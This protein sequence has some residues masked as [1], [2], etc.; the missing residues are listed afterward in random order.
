VGDRDV[1]YVTT[2]HGTYASKAIWPEPD[3]PLAK[4]LQARLGARLKVIP[5]RWSGGNNPK[6]RGKAA[7]QLQK[8]LLRLHEAD[9]AATQFVIAH[10]HAGNVALYAMRDPDLQEIVSGVVCLATPFLIAAPRRIAHQGMMVHLVFTAVLVG[11]TPAL[12]LM[13][14]LRDIQWGWATWLIATVATALSMS[15]VIWG[16]KGV[17]K[18]S[19]RLLKAM[20]LPKLDSRKVLILR[21]AGDEA[22]GVLV[23]FQF[24][25]W[26]AIRLYAKLLK[27]QA[28]FRRQAREWSKHPFLLIVAT[29]VGFVLL[30]GVV[31]LMVYLKA[32]MT[33]TLVVVLVTMAVFVLCPFFLIV[34]QLGMAMFVF[35]L[36]VGGVLLGVIVLLSITLLPLG[37]QVALSNVLLDVTAETT[38]P[39]NWQIHLLTPAEEVDDAEQSEATEALRHSI[40]EDPRTHDMIARWI[41][42]KL[43][44]GGSENA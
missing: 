9:E 36:F 30:M 32:S 24:I 10:S 12:L 42:E 23:F 25:T 1:V 22:S 11:V 27:M 13:H 15:L 14:W 6:E 44:A 16:L 29:L 40:Y 31:A 4:A 28:A 17:D 7:E 38:P 43:D 21:S 26:S 34:R 19:Q 8:H 18:G 20:E 33:M 35:D 2:V 41:E 39:G 5:L 37:R 3:S